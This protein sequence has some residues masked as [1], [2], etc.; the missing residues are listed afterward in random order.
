MELLVFTGAAGVKSEGFYFKRAKSDALTPSV[1]IDNAPHFTGNENAT[2]CLSLSGRNWAWPMTADFLEKQT[3]QHDKIHLVILDTSQDEALSTTVKT[4]LESSDYGKKTYLQQTVGRK[5]LV[6]EPRDDVIV[7]VREA[8]CKMCNTFVL[9]CTE[10]LAFFLEDDVVPPVDAYPRLVRS[11]GPNIVSVTATIF[12]RAHADEPIA[13][14]W[15]E[16]GVARTAEIRSGVTAIDGNGFGCLAVRGPFIATHSFKV[17][18]G[19]LCYDHNF[20]KRAREEGWISLI[21]WD[22]R[23]RHYLDAT[24]WH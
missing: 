4:W 17:G 6:D 23:A 3:W 5:G 10:P 18:P 7:E 20:F 13:W 14:F 8:L 9:Y 12:R 2:L 21:D 19:I 16:H 1:T 24:T 15:N 11:L 22:C